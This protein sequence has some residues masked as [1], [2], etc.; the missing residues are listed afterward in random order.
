LNVADKPKPAAVAEAATWAKENSC[1]ISADPV[2][3]D[4]AE[5]YKAN[6]E[7]NADD[8]PVEQPSHHI[9]A[10]SLPIPDTGPLPPP[11]ENPVASFPGVA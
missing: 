6:N 9:S 8:G 5:G 4:K 3:G 10:T 7:L 11:Y 2:A 1:L